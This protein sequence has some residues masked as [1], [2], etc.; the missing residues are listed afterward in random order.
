MCQECESTWEVG[1]LQLDNGNYESLAER[2]ERLYIVE[3]WDELIFTQ[4]TRGS[5]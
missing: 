4:F 1:E 3:Q 5:E 2:C